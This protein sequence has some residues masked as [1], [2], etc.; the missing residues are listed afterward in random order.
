MNMHICKMKM[1]EQ[2][3]AQTGISIKQVERT[4]EL[5]EN[6]STIPFVA[7]YRKE[8]TG[9]L[10][11]VQLEMIQ[12][13]WQ[14]WK[15]LDDRRNAMLA[16]LEERGLLTLEIKAALLLAAS[17][18]DAEDIYM[19]YK[20]RRRTKATIARE[21]GLEPLAKMIMSQGNDDPHRMAQRFVGKDVQDSDAALQGARDIIAEWVSEHPGGRQSVRQQFERFA[22]LIS[23]ISRL[24]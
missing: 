10:D 21:Q 12:E 16:S 17:I 4:L 9:G 3:S 5:F 23:K 24:F 6:G 20:P 2:L 19:P 14:Q 22:V 15:K 7:R 8:M 13:Q 11:E 18:Q 1:L